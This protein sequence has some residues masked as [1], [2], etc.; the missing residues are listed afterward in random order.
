[1]N[2]E[3]LLV[4]VAVGL[5]VVF[6]VI[7]P[8][9]KERQENGRADSARPEPREA[10]EAALAPVPSAAPASGFETPRNGSIGTTALVAPATTRPARRSPLGS[11]SGTRHGIVLAAVLGPCRAQ[12]PFV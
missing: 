2:L 10:A 11:L 5:A 6:N 9:V 8:W 1:M 12:T 3:T 4:V 7:L